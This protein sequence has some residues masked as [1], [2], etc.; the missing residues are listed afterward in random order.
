[1]DTQYDDETDEIEFLEPE[2]EDITTSDHRRFY[3]SHKLWLEIDEDE[4]MVAAIQ[5][6]MEKDRF[7]P[8]VWFISDHGN[9]HLMSLTD[10]L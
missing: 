4:D 3:Q 5:A 6:R 1:M 7:W 9:A 10:E 8:N 2:D